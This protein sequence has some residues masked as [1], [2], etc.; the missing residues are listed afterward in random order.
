MD[1]KSALKIVLFL[2]LASLCRAEDRKADPPSLPDS[3]TLKNGAVL[4]HIS[5]VRWQIDVVVIKHVGGVDPIRLD[6]LAPESRAALEAYQ[7]AQRAG[8]LLKPNES[9]LSGE[10]FIATKGR[11]TIKFG[12][13]RVRIYRDFDSSNFSEVQKRV[14]TI[15][16]TRL[17]DFSMD[18]KSE[19]IAKTQK[20][21]EE[22][23]HFIES[24][25]EPEFSTYTNSEGKFSLKAPGIRNYI[26]VVV[27]DKQMATSASPNEHYAWLV[28]SPD[29]KDPQSIILGTQNA[30]PLGF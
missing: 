20:I 6:Y 30:F 16:G 27:S 21:R 28:K 9:V 7:A 29:I 4:R 22:W 18:S 23:D 10:I 19:F 13:T 1:M 25:P 5:I 14:E 26:L 24:L 11:E 17:G 8:D 2:A 3:V 15:M 12:G